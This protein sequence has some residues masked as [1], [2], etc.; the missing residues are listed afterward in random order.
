VR[1]ALVPRVRP[2]TSLETNEGGTGHSAEA[3]GAGP[4]GPFVPS[5]VEG[6]SHGLDAGGAA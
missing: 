6:R 4:K 2:S 5:E 3:L 1:R